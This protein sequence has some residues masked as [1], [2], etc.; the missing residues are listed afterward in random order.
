MNQ[1][2]LINF[3]VIL[4]VYI[5]FSHHSCDS[6]EQNSKVQSCTTK[7][8]SVCSDS[9]VMRWN[10]NDIENNLRTW[11]KS[12]SFKLIPNEYEIGNENNCKHLF[13]T[14]NDYFRRYGPDAISDQAMIFGNLYQ[15]QKTISG[16]TVKF[17]GP[18]WA[19]LNNP[20]DWNNQVFK[21]NI[22]C[23]NAQKC[24]DKKWIVLWC[25]E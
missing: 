15:H 14:K 4:L 7:I 24:S 19:D 5:V 16:E 2:L 23:K 22:A 10:R 1:D 8:E 25:I 12:L 13:V 6:F 20:D 11:M 17:D 9:A 21:R 3:V 18:V